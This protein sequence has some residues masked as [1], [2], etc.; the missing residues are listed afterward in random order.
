MPLDSR[1]STPPE[2][3]LPAASRHNTKIY[4]HS[5]AW[6]LGIGREARESRDTRRD[7]R[8]SRDSRDSRD[9]HQREYPRTPPTEWKSHTQRKMLYP[10]H[11]DQDCSSNIAR[12][13]E[14]E[15]DEEEAYW[16]S[17]RTLYEKT[18]GCSRPRPVSKASLPWYPG[19]FS[20]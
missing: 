16:A 9:T 4:E 15:E 10:S 8:E 12:K 7:T 5:D 18:P 14:E 3:Q 17:M 19:C 20:V 6:S 1:P 2:V 11:L 13:R